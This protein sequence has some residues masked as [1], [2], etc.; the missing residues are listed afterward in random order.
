MTANTA[1]GGLRSGVS[2]LSD[3]VSQFKPALQLGT[4]WFVPRA[5]LAHI[6]TAAYGA[7]M[8]TNIWC[9]DVVALTC[10]VGFGGVLQRHMFSL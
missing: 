10:M 9:T 7:Q 4:W 5:K 6:C 2:A 1:T 3:S 8:G